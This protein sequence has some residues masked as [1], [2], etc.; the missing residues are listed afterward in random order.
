[1]KKGH[2]INVTS[3]GSKVATSKIG[4]DTAS[5]SLT[6][7][8]YNLA[9]ATLT[10]QNV[11]NSFIDT[12]KVQGTT[13]TD[14]YNSSVKTPNVLLTIPKANN[15]LSEKTFSNNALSNIGA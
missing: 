3:T 10:S 6:I 5:Y 12:L 7:N 11:S 13:V 4:R 1:D 14:T 15:M 2:L 8:P 9:N